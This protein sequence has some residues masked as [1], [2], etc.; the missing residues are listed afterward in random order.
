MGLFGKVIVRVL[1]GAVLGAALGVSA[2]VYSVWYVARQDDR[3]A[4]DT[5]VVLG[6]AQYNGK[7]SP[8]FES[9]LQHAKH[10]YEDGYAKVIVTVGG[11]R[12]GDNFTEAGAG[13]TWLIDQGVPADA[14]VAV[15]TGSNTLTSAVA[16]GDTYRA[17]GWTSAVVVTDPWHTLRAENM[18][19]DAGI[20]T[21]GSPT[22]SGPA[23]QTRTTQF[24][25]ILR[26]SAA[27]LYYGVTGNSAE[28][29]PSIG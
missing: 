18:I 4:A 7:P 27:L 28:T 1:V 23:V 17:E 15:P 26:E 16:L 2:V 5:I 29:G 9:R 6:S 14:V 19:H 13:R 3:Q 10:L 21:Y 8:I 20:V 24:E 11:N 12:A 22:R 25:Y